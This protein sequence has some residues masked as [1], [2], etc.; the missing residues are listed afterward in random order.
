[1]RPIIDVINAI[2]NII[3]DSF[4][5]KRYLVEDLDNLKDSITYTAPEALPG[6]WH[7]L[8]NILVLH[9]QYIDHD[10]FAENKEWIVRIR[11]VVSNDEDYR[12]YLS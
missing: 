2:I 7:I 5:N 3:P 6:C 9:L 4:N 8:G 10:T 11:D 12:K 1:M